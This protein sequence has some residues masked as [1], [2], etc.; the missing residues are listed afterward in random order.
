MDRKPSFKVNLA[1]SVPEVLIYDDI[2]RSM[3]GGLSAK[4]F[5]TEWGKIP[6]SAAKV[7]I[8]INSGGGDVFDGVAIY[9]TIRRHSGHKVVDIDGGAL[10]IA[11]VIAMAGDEI[12]M[13]DGAM[14]MIHKPWSMTVGDADELRKRA[15]L[16]DQVEEQV[17]GI[18]AR[19]TRMEPDKLADMLR[20]E[21]W[22][23]SEDAV[24]MG[25]ADAVSKDLAIAARVNPACITSQAPNRRERLS[26]LFRHH[27]KMRSRFS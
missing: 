26:A 6:A 24:A 15:D 27:E 21:T 8:R 23:D 20:E 17:I 9:N 3:F 13:A 25:F 12:R 10:S 7:S 16:M 19:R 11:S 18:Y 1:A 14:M 2:G 5:A 4:D 22:M